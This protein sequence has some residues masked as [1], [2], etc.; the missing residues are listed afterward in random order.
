[1]FSRR[2]LFIQ[3]DLFIPLLILMLVIAKK[4]HCFEITH[5][6]QCY[7]ISIPGLMALYIWWP[8]L[9]AERIGRGMPSG[10]VRKCPPVSHIWFR[11]N[12]TFKFQMAILFPWL[13]VDIYTMKFC[14][15]LF[16]ILVFLIEQFKGIIQFSIYKQ[17]LI[18][19]FKRV[20][21]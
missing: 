8:R 21:V 16:W 9:D 4:L 6:K 17:N 20:F 5:T 1:M 13:V 12:S 18:S 10:A 14:F 3:C 7:T 11:Q 19:Y 2:R 15:V